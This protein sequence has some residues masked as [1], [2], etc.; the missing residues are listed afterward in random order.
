MNVKMLSEHGTIP[1]RGHDDDA[2]LD[3]YLSEDYW[4]NPDQTI[5]VKTDVALQIPQGYWG[6]LVGRSSTLRKR[7]LL[8]NTGIIDEGYRGEL[9]VNLHN[10]GKKSVQ[11]KKGERLAQL[12]I[13]P[14]FS[15]HMDLNVVD[16]LD[17]H[18]RG[19]LG[20]GSTGL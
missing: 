2:G 12:I 6:M 13:L 18:V 20:F 4:V 7:G 15:M 1:T 11:V 17:E 16:R 5:D 10:P 8:V 19:E 14:N 3:I 9:F